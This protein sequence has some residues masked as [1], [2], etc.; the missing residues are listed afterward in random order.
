VMFCP[1]NM[2]KAYLLPIFIVR[3]LPL[4]LHIVT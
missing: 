1:G 4:G 3:V 2:H